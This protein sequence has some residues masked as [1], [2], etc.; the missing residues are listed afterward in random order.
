MRIHIFMV[1]IHQHHCVSVFIY[2]QTGK[3]RLPDIQTKL[4]S[5]NFPD[6]I[7]P[8]PHKKVNL[9]GG[10]WMG[11]ELQSPLCTGMQSALAKTS[12]KYK[13]RRI[14]NVL[15]SPSSDHKLGLSVPSGSFCE[16]GK[17]QGK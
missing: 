17:F 7:L 13:M 3:P 5:L 6:V 14:A 4:R 9:Q 2:S 10:K 15:H 8:K 12:V 1:T 11:R 16:A